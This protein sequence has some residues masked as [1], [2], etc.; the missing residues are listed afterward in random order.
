M[1]FVNGFNRGQLIMMDFEANV[2]ASSWAR[3]ADW[4]VDA[5]PMDSLGFNNV[6]NS[7]GRPPYRS[8]DMLKLFMYGYKKK[9]RSSYQLE[10]ACRVNLEVIWLMNGLRPSARKIAYFR[11]NNSKAFKQAFRHFLL[12][13]KEMD[14]IN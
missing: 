11:K 7:E 10:E 1:D 13:L 2:T 3:V 5:L 14:L 8:S 4:F 6:L 12:M 9:L